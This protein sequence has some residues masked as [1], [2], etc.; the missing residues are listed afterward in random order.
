VECRYWLPYEQAVELRRQVPELDFIG[1]AVIRGRMRI[2][3]YVFN[4]T[5]PAG[6][7]RGPGVS[8]V[9][10][11][12]LETFAFERELYADLDE[13]GLAPPPEMSELRREAARLLRDERLS[14]L[15]RL[16]F[17]VP[18]ASSVLRYNRL[19][20]TY[21]GAGLSW[22]PGPRLRIDALGGY[23]TGTEHAGGRIGVAVRPAARWTLTAA[24]YANELRDIGPRAGLPGAL[25]SVTALFDADDYT[26]PYLASGVEAGV[27]RRAGAWSVGAVLRHEEHDGARRWDGEPV[28]PSGASDEDEF[29]RALVAIDRGRLT[30][31]TLM[32]QRSAVAPGRWGWSTDVRVEPGHFEGGS[33]EG[34]SYVRVLATGALE[35]RSDD[36]ASDATL[37]ATAG[38][39]TDDEPAQ[40]QFL[41]G[42]RNTLPGYD[43]RS[44]AGTRLGLL[45]LELARDVAAPWLRVRALGALGWA[46]GGSV[47]RLIREPIVFDPRLDQ[48]YPI[49]PIPD[50]DGAR[51]SVGFGVAG[52]WDQLRLDLVR[53]LNDGEWQLLFSIAPDFWSM[54]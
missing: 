23:A 10:R 16:R 18:S 52:F 26:D 11:D 53:G 24:G 20:G 51:A 8:I 3:D 28:G 12:A 25:N 42:G 38:A 1:G 7:F 54:L 13:E 17:N 47:G 4:D 15:P 49:E 41:L 6:L 48:V 19:E 22:V 14:G 21:F 46:A 9:P 50:T 31:A 40:R 5:L 36:L 27:E 39:T 34:S 32:L 35:F 44:F 43:Y 29:S 37:R 30:S 33:F 45:E 2:G